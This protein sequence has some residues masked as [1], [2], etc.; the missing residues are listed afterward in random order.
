M[1]VRAGG[2]P[3]N[4]TFSETRGGARQAV[5]KH[6]DVIADRVGSNL[7]VGGKSPRRTPETLRP[8]S[9]NAFRNSSER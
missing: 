7:I 5:D 6:D 1:Y 4:F 3:P 2:E 9:I 8:H